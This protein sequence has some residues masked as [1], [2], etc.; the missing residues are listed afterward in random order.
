MCS[1]FSQSRVTDLNSAGCLIY[2][3]RDKSHACVLYQPTTPGVGR[4][5]LLLIVYYDVVPGACGVEGA[6]ALGLDLRA[7]VD[8]AGGPVAC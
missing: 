5:G 4:S 6:A 7:R 2:R 3:Q 8:R 1:F